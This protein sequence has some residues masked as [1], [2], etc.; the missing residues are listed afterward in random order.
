MQYF[1]V[2]TS[3]IDYIVYNSYCCAVI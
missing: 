1:A 2:H 3:Y